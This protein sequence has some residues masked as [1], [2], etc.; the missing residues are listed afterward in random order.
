[1]INYSF[2]ITN[3]NRS[4]AY[5]QNLLSRGFLPRVAICLDPGGKI[6]PEHTES[7]KMIG[8][9]TGQQLLRKCSD[10]DIEFD[11]KEHVLATLKK[12]NVKTILIKTLD[13][14][15]PEV[16]KAVCAAET[17]YFVYSGPGGV[18]LN[19]TLLSQGK[20]FIHVHPGWLPQFCGST[21]LYYSLLQDN[22]IAA[23]VLL[24]DE[25]IDAGPVLYRKHFVIS[26]RNI[27]MDYTLDP[28]V[29]TATLVDYFNSK[30]SV[31]SQTLVGEDE[32]RNDFYIIHPVL[33]HL[34]I[35]KFK[36]Q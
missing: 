34:A 13:I 8:S 3:N 29:R 15:D 20:Q 11:E 10:L 27:D 23:S 17:E 5:V 28:L 31:S 35:S 16:I 22:S 14:N 26:D 36:K 2:L 24:L 25:N 6:L 1:V 12:Y 19:K 30:D 7:D 18:L 32:K 33:K 9:E 21:V 4:K